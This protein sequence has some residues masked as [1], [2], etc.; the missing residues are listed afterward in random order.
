VRRA[1]AIA[2]LA[3]AV[4]GLAGCSDGPR[5][6]ETA[7]PM[8]V[9]KM[10]EL[11]PPDGVDPATGAFA[12]RIAPLDKVS[13]NVIDTPEMTGDFRADSAGKIVLPYLGEVQAGG[14]TPAQ[15]S[16]QIDRGLR[17]GHFINDPRVAVNLNEADSLNFTIGGQV[18]QPGE[19]TAT[20]GTTLMRAI[21][22]AKGLNEYARLNDVVIFRTVNG[23]KLAALYDIGAIRL[24]RYADPPIYP[25]DVVEVGDSTARRPMAQLISAL[26]LLT[27]PVV[28]ALERIH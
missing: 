3:A 20:P 23:Q 16:S 2:A 27:T 9:T 5:L 19:Y 14:L 25:H 4:F 22:K 8:V 12:Y 21:D 7:E 18:G 6:G 13:L 26:P 1:G 10:T 15:L 17:S 11:P 28:L 24:G